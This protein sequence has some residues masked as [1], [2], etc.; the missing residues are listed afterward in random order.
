MK[1]GK[2][3]L[4]LLLTIIIVVCAAPLV[5]S[6]EYVS[7]PSD[8]KYYNGSYYKVFDT[9]QSWTSAK[10]YCES[11]GGHLVTI[12]SSGEQSF[13]SSLIRGNPA[14][15]HYFIGGRR[16]SYG[17]PWYWIT[18]EK[19]E[20]NCWGYGEDTQNLS[21]HYIT[22]AS[23]TSTQLTPYNWYSN[24]NYD[25]GTS[26]EWAGKYT[27]FIC[28]WESVRETFSGTLEST[29]ISV[30]LNG[31]KTWVSE[32]I[33][34]GISYPVHDNCNLW[35]TTE[36]KGKNVVVITENN[37]VIFCQPK[38]TVKSW[39]SASFNTVPSKIQYT[40]DGFNSTAIG[41]SLRLTNAFSSAFLGTKEDAASYTELDT[42][43]SKVTLKSSNP[44]LISF[45]GEAECELTD[46]RLA[47]LKAGESISTTCNATINQDYKMD[48]KTENVEISYLV[49]YANEATIKTCN[50]SKTITVE[51][52]SYEPDG[53]E[54]TN[55]SNLD[56]INEAVEKLNKYSNAIS[57]DHLWTNG[58]LSKDQADVIAAE[59]LLKIV[60]TTA[61]ED[62]YETKIADAAMKKIFGEYKPQYGM[63]TKTVEHTV[64]I[65]SEKYGPL[66]I[67]IY[68]D[69]S[70][71]NLDDTDF[72][73]FSSINYEIVDGDRKD[74]IP[75][76]YQSGS[77]GMAVTADVEKFSNAAINVADNAIKEQYDE[78]WGKDANKVADMLFNDLT[79][80][81][82][83]RSKYKSFSNLVYEAMTAPTK[84]GWYKCPVDIYIYDSQGVLCASVIDNEVVSSCDKAHIEIIGDEKV[85]TLYDETY[86][87]EI[88]GLGEGAMDVTIEE[89]ANLSG[90]I[91]SI[92]INE[93]PLDYGVVYCQTIDNDLM[94][95][96]D[97]YSL[98]NKTN[99]DVIAVTDSECYIHTHNSE[100]WTTVVEHTCTE[101]GKM[102]SE[103]NKCGKKITVFELS[104]GHIY[105]EILTS[106]TCTEAGSVT[107]TCTCGDTYTETLEALGHKFD[108]S[109]CTVCGYDKAEA[110]SCRCHKDN[111]FARII[112][113]IINFFNKL[114]KKNAVCTCGVAH[115]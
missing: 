104:S 78:V 62:S 11:L 19:F 13:I 26:A 90:I 113:N 95:N 92:N 37:K 63:Y 79:K 110:C 27:G 25:T 61:P 96:E 12:T 73:S 56:G 24:M 106:P 82:I 88:I 14:K 97:V 67:R 76:Y 51:N 34:D 75:E 39:I 50:G 69:V 7:P 17:S 8:A 35:H 105:S 111:F 18:G 55:F 86:T 30:E 83:S 54:K 31:D 52:K 66:E 85:V 94:C 6:A 112:W 74:E 3:V 2:S 107:Y 109:V 103:C 49:E 10:S 42:F 68:S 81:I 72:A 20:F 89:Y 91:K 36:Y 40:Q 46:V 5:Y 71:F 22:I 115:Y 65:E 1:Q 99:N 47:H 41:V 23:S 93:I 70:K 87:I 4:S 59:Y 64:F 102:V 15:K 44:E 33:V 57:L 9:S 28:E 80:E 29:T 58:I 114:F 101:N 48:K 98:T 21:Q 84:K 60:M 38:E 45:G 108:G 53:P 43:I 77:A 32:I 16:N 100:E